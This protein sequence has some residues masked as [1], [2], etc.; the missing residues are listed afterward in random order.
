MVKKAIYL[1]IIV[2]LL[3]GAAYMASIAPYHIYTLTLTEGVDTTFLKMKPGKKEFFNGEEILLNEPDDMT[4]TALYQ[5][6]HLGHY[7][8]PLPLNH[9]VLST[10]PII[11]NDGLG[12]RLGASFQNDKGRELFSFMMERSY[13]FEMSLGDQKIFLLPVFKNYIN[14]KSNE[15][16]WADLF[17]KTL[18]LPSNQGE[19]FF[20][21]LKT[22]RKVSY[23]DLV[24]NLYILY[25]RYFFIDNNA[26]KITFYPNKK[27]GIIELPSNDPKLKVERVYI[28]DQGY[29]YPLL[30]KTRI[31][32]KAAAN[33]RQK[34]LFEINYKKTTTDSAIPIYAEYKRLGYNQRIYQQ[35]MT[36]LFSAWSHDLNNRDF[37]RVI[38]LFLERGKLNLKYLKPF[39]EYAFRKFGTTFAS[40]QEF[41]NE[42][43]DEKLKRKMIDE[44]EAELKKESDLKKPT[45][46][47]QFE[48]SEEKVDYL[49]QKAKDKKTNS[50][51][52]EKS[53]S[54]E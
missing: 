47:G 5:K 51:E 44:L 43:A 41:L 39:Y 1:S 46:E 35:G 8:I 24:Y 37:V 7:E 27:M 25:N 2:I 30:I 14:R 33:M 48:N 34:V 18:S 22:L 6:F 29:V 21:S 28:I 11:K 15:E 26:T 38:I 17:K 36:Y 42:S 54:I 12:P 45:F 52:A 4:D 13:K 50:D 23:H 40:A 9:P 16:V 31:D 49:L 19:S 3:G 32:N 20:E 10:I 53:L